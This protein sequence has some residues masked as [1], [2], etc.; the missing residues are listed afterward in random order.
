LAK[1]LASQGKVKFWT[2]DFFRELVDRVNSDESLSKLTRGLNT[3]LLFD[4]N[5]KAV[6]IAAEDGKLAVR[7]PPTEKVAEFRFTASTEEWEKIAKGQAKMQGEVVSGRVKFRGSMPKM[8]LYLG[9]IVGLEAKVMKTI[10]EMDIE[11]Q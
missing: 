8:L 6:L 7:E 11:F 3:S 9:K 5:G 1:T 10:K 4:C 2:M